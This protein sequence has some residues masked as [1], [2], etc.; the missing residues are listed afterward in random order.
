MTKEQV[1]KALNDLEVQK[2]KLIGKLELLEEQNN[3]KNE[4]TK[5]DA[6]ETTGL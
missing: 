2:I 4:E 3:E 1:I 6:P 5:S